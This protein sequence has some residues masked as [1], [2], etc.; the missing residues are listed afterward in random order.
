MESNRGL[1]PIYRSKPLTKTPEQQHAVHENNDL[2][3]HEKYLNYTGRV[4]KIGFR[5][6]LVWELPT[7]SH[8]SKSSFIIRKEIIFSNIVKE[9]IRNR[10][11]NYEGEL[12][13]EVLNFKKLFLK[14]YES[15]HHG[16]CMRFDYEIT[17]EDI[18]ECNG[19]LY[20]IETDII[21]STRQDN[22]PLHPHCYD[23]SLEVA[24][25]FTDENDRTSGVYM[26][27]V[28]N[29]GVVGPRFAA[30]W[31][32]V[33]QVPVVKHEL[34][35]EGL[36]YTFVGVPSRDSS[37]NKNSKKFVPIDKLGDVK[38]L[39]KSFAEAAS[40]PDHEV[41]MN[42][43]IKQLDF[44]SKQI[45]A[46]TTITR[47]ELDLEKMD[48]EKVLSLMQEKLDEKERQ[49]RVLELDLQRRL[50]R[51]EH[52]SKL[53]QMRSKDMYEEKSY[54]RKDTSEW[55]KFIP[56]VLLGA[57]AV[58]MAVNKLISSN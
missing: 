1:Y 39:Y 38:W 55:V 48:K 2:T 46:E 9:N 20:H 24:D 28:D 54:V 36:Y 3:I 15:E 26:H 49:N 31:G 41:G 47:S 21:L 16:L 17:I 29:R 44:Q 56:T 33:V 45:S 19:T 51:E 32:E 12:T 10:I 30:I 34:M 27:M 18:L 22:I 40:S 57:G 52:D 13:D 4:L 14:A 23:A 50:S 43:E 8:K 35:Q 25:L 6:G 7:R 58:Y 53:N 37:K 42:Y 5:D 11:L